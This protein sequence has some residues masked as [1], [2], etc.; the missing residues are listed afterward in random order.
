MNNLGINIQTWFRTP[1]HVLAAIAPPKLETRRNCVHRTRGPR[2]RRSGHLSRVC[3]EFV[4]RQARTVFVAGSFN[5]WRPELTP[6]IPL[7]GGWW[8]RGL[9][10]PPG[11]YEY[12][13]VV[14]GRWMPDPNAASAARTADGKINSVL[15]VAPPQTSELTP[16]S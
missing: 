10:L 16:P 14:D 8:T 4:H 7:G 13:L 11:R 12:R 2:R 3:L 15:I 5:H 9:A 6:M 1:F